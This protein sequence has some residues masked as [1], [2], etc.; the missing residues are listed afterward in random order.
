MV[1]SKVLPPPAG[2]NFIF[3]IFYEVTPSLYDFQNVVKV[4]F[5]PKLISHAMYKWV[6]A[7][8]IDVSSIPEMK[9]RVIKLMCLLEKV[10]LPAFF[11][12]QVHLVSHLVEEVEIAGTVHARWMFS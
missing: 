9:E 4:G 1:V 5:L 6:C 11:D 12:I 8:E 10:F 3:V 7:K 2:R